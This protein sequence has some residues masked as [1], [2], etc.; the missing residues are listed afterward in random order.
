MYLTTAQEEQATPIV[1]AFLQHIQDVMLQG[2]E[3]VAR[4]L[5]P[6]PFYPVKFAGEFVEKQVVKL[7]GVYTYELDNYKSYHYSEHAKAGKLVEGERLVPPGFP[8]LPYEAKLYMVQG[9]HKILR[10]VRN[11]EKEK[12]AA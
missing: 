2:D 12:F 10:A 11:K 9:Y 3:A 6:D 5:Q 4:E 1:T 7:E 8:N